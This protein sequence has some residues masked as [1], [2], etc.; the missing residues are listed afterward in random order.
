[1]LSLNN[2]NQT[3]GFQ[4]VTTNFLGTKEAASFIIDTLK[5]LPKKYWPTKSEYYSSKNIGLFSF[6]NKK[7]FVDKVPGT[8]LFGGYAKL[9]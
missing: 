9:F 1:M 2:Q 6:E 5:K 4:I 3:L 7:E 8:Y